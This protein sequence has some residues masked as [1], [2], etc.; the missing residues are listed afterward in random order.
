MYDRYNRHIRYLRVSV[1]DRCD[2]RC[3]YCMPAAGIPLLR[4]ADILSFEEIEAVV[5]A[6]VSMGIDKVR[7]TGGEPLV[8]RGIVELTRLVA[9]VPGIDDFA[10]TT[11]GTLLAEFAG[12]LADAG[13]QRVNVSLD[14]LAPDRFRELTRGGELDDVL[15]G[16]AAAREA[17][18]TP[19]KLNCVVTADA[20]E[21]D[22]VRVAEFAAANHCTVQFIRRMELDSGRFWPVINGSGGDCPRCNRLRLTSDGMIRPCLFSDLAFSS[23]DLGP[24]TALRQAVA[25]KPASGS[26]SRHNRFSRVGG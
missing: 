6:A 11:N 22:A 7:L 17:G 25:A 24:E 3:V 4:H 1:T 23:R 26:T 13:L 5:R 8:R 2:L 9:A 15:N 10:M 19:I 18:L 20:G 21:P 14:T 12:P 16:I